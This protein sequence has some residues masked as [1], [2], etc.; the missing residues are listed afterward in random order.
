[1]ARHLETALLGLALAMLQGAISRAEQVITPIATSGAVGGLGMTI[2]S[3]NN[4]G[5]VA[6]I[7][8]SPGTNGLYVGSGGVLTPLI[9]SNTYFNQYGAGGGSTLSVDAGPIIN[10]A[11]Q[12]SFWANVGANLGVA[13]I[14]RAQVGSVTT[15]VSGPAPVGAGGFSNYSGA[16]QLSNSG[17]VVFAANRLGGAPGAGMLVGN[18][19]ALTPIIQT[20]TEIR[21]PID[22]AMSNNGGLAYGWT[23][24]GPFGGVIGDNIFILKDGITTPIASS[25]VNFYSF[26][27][28]NDAGYVAASSGSQIQLGNGGP[29]STVVGTSLDFSHF[30][31]VSLNNA[32]ELAFYALT[33][34]GQRGIYRGPDPIADKI[35]A[36]GD[37]LLGSTVTQLAF[38]RR[39]LNDAGQVAFWAKMENGQQGVFVAS[40]PEPATISLLAVGALS[41]A[42]IS[43]CR[44]RRR[45]RPAQ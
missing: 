25:N 14:L 1:M 32:N 34:T 9:N 6:F 11:G 23:T 3:I 15:I 27:A 24:L 4:H 20:D 36:T 30:G 18:G 39:G 41:L 22:P 37:T 7:D 21:V 2:P 38:G 16:P 42:G 17:D 43:A 29:F 5:Q 44:R 45:K 12:V 13:G 33:P 31:A 28:V 10:D 40:V 35:I 19:G 26:L 8:T